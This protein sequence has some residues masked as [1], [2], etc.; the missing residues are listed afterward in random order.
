[1]ATRN[2]DKFDIEAESEGQA[3][4]VLR[5]MRPNGVKSKK[6]RGILNRQVVANAR[7]IDSILLA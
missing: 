6:M 3:N 2:W 4:K 7:I 1:M 5:S